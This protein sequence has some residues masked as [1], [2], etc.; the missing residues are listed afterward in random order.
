MFVLLFLLVLI[1]S[2]FILNLSTKIS[3]CF[4]E[5]IQIPLMNK[6]NGVFNVPYSYTLN[7]TYNIDIDDDT[8]NENIDNDD[9]EVEDNIE[10]DDN[11]DTEVEDDSTDDE[12]EINNLELK[13]IIPR[14]RILVDEKLDS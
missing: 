12:I 14:K 8:E 13:K 7:K 10:T 4:I 6:L 3:E 5:N 2:L 1:N 9:A 11:D